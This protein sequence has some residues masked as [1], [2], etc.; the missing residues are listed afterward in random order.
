MTLD[1]LHNEEQILAEIQDALARLEQGT[2]GVCEGCHGDIPRER[3]LTLP[4][5]RRCVSC[6]DRVN[7]AP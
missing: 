7:P 5:A 4:Y 3:L 1:L 6:A 2:F